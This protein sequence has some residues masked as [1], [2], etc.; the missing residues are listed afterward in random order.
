MSL[1][2]DVSQIFMRIQLIAISLFLLS[3][4]DT[5]WINYSNRNYCDNRCGDNR[6]NSWLKIQ[7][8]KIVITKTKTQTEMIWTYIKLSQSYLY[9]LLFWHS[10]KVL[11]RVCKKKIIIGSAMRKMQK[12]THCLSVINLAFGKTV[13]WNFQVCVL[14]RV[15]RIQMWKFKPETKVWLVAMEFGPKIQFSFLKNAVVS[16]FTKYLTYR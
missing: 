2:Y 8:G 1:S 15:N 16:Q 6:M 11:P 5:T 7:T 10:K 13:K 9:F 3:W 12:K 14:L 4:L